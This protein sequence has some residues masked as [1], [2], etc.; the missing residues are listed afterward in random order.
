MRQAT[1]EHRKF[2]WYQCLDWEIKKRWL[3]DR[4]ISSTCMQYC[5]FI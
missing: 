5:L 4:K 1:N 3:V 2:A